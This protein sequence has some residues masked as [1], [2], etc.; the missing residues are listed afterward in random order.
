MKKTNKSMIKKDQLL[1]ERWQVL[2][3]INSNEETLKEADLAGDLALKITTGK[4]KTKQELEKEM[5][6][7][8]NKLFRKKPSQDDVEWLTSMLPQE[9]EAPP[10]KEELE[11]Q[12]E[13][14]IPETSQENQQSDKPGSINVSQI[15][16]DF[17]KA[18]SD[19]RS[20]INA[21]TLSDMELAKIFIYLDELGSFKL[22][23]SKRNKR[24]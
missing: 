13:K 4:I 23:E 11:K 16:S 3:G 5:N 2:A 15:L 21:D 18:S 8:W 20:T 19:I 24:R 1:L 10:N 6:S 12:I 7:L 17:P 22:V 14:E 9:G